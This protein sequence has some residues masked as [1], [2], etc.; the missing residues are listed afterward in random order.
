MSDE[1]ICEA[2]FADF[3]AVMRLYRQLQPAD[4]ILTNGEDRR[5]FEDIPRTPNLRRFVLERDGG[6]QATAYLNI[7]PNLTRS[8]S[9]YAL[10]ENVV[11]DADARGAGLG[12]RILGHT[13]ESA[14]GAGCYKVMLLTGSKR[15]STQAFY[16]ACGASRETTSGAMWRIHRALDGPPAEP[17]SWPPSVARKAVRLPSGQGDLQNVPRGRILV[18]FNERC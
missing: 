8:A 18:P 5:V 13:L 3:E 2:E 12:K 15:L 11:V 7:I 6:V 9:P 10:I 16:R 17:C 4:P 1:R 14:W